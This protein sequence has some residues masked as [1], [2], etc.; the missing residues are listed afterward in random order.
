MASFAHGADRDDPRRAY[1]PP[2][3]NMR[4]EE[5]IK[6]NS[7]AAR[8]SHDDPMRVSSMI[9]SD[10]PD[11]PRDVYPRRELP[12]RMGSEMERIPMQNGPPPLRPP[13]QWEY[14]AGSEPGDWRPGLAPP[15]P[16]M[17]SRPRDL[18]SPPHISRYDME[19]HIHSASPYRV[20]RRPSPDPQH[21]AYEAERRRLP[22]AKDEYEYQMRARDAP[23]EPMHGMYHRASPEREPMHAM[24]HM[25]SYPPPKLRD[26][27]ADMQH[28]PIPHHHHVVPH[29]HPHHHHVVPHHHHHH[30]HH[31]NPGVHD[32][33]SPPKGVPWQEQ[34]PAPIS[35]VRNSS[36]A[37]RRTP[38]AEP[39]LTAVEAKQRE[40]ASGPRVD[41]EPVWEY[42]DRCEQVEEYERK[43]QKLLHTEERE[44]Q[45]ATA[46]PASS[47]TEPTKNQPVPVPDSRILLGFGLGKDRGR[48]VQHLG[49]FLYDA[50][51]KSCL[52]AE[53]LVSNIGATVEV[54]ICGRA[55]GFGITEEEWRAEEA[56]HQAAVLERIEQK[57]SDGV[58]PSLQSLALD[59]QDRSV[60]PSPNMPGRWRLGW[61]GLEHALMNREIRIANIW[62]DHQL[63]QET[64]KRLKR[65]H[66]DSLASAL[67]HSHRAPATSTHAVDAEQSAWQF[68]SQ[69]SLARR[70]LWGTDVYTDDSDVLAMC[71]HA[72]WIEPPHI[73]NVPEWLGGG[74]TSNVSKAWARLT[75]R[76]ERA[77]GNLPPPPRRAPGS[78]SGVPLTCDLSVT[79][80]I[81]PKLI[82]YKGC[83]RGGIKSRSWGNTHDGASL[84]VESVELRPVRM[85]GADRSRAT[86]RVR[87]ANRPRR[88]WRTWR[89]SGER[90]VRSRCPPRSPMP[91]HRARTAIRSWPCRRLRPRSMADNARSGRWRRRARSG[92]V[93]GLRC[94]C[95]AWTRNGVQL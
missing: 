69:P 3:M 62:N 36:P 5:G 49:S 38:D 80:R 22:P 73:P 56:R 24:S 94:S 20:P 93:K 21:H 57:A 42:L 23:Y 82:L 70:K 13:P 92:R 65:T 6:A 53:L 81:A 78:M 34:T 32:D 64:N 14:G 37:P 51:G 27:P 31:P 91:R 77:L 10:A 28:A 90:R 45:D 75:E 15:D 84:V 67:P 85:H 52:P 11:L 61:R 74:G 68:W 9:S 66:R 50:S 12:P 72:G 54:R 48:A 35:D 8:T 83:H 39:V 40:L 30:H 59:V 89:R 46:P 88:A 25:S 19:R 63:R 7:E 1:I 33:P 43:R 41:S 16:G 55:I 29:H 58:L 60:D 87:A 44:R 2:P 71:V 4:G 95:M 76:Q 86:P 79:L 47:L 17:L 26:E 18:P